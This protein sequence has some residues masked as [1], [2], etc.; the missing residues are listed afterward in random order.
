MF[1]FDGTKGFLTSQGLYGGLYGGLLCV[2]LLLVPLLSNLGLL[3]NGLYA[4]FSTGFLSKLSSFFWINS[5]F[6]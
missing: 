1:A 4:G 3:S 2:G 6:F 5:S